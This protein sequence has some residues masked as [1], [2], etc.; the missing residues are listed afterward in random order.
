MCSD[1]DVKPP[2]TRAGPLCVDTAKAYAFV[3]LSVLGMDGNV[4]SGMD[5]WDGSVNLH[6]RM[7]ETADI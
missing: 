4:H 2:C 6:P 1:V 3:V 5:V 7:P